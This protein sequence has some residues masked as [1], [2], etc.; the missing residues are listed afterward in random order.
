MSLK[1]I[2]LE[3]LAITRRIVTDG[4]E[5]IPAWR[6]ETPDGAWIILTG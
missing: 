4:H 6:I 3:Q 5:N 2:M 1:P